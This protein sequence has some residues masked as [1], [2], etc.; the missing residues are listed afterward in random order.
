[1]AALRVPFNGQNVLDAQMATEATQLEGIV[2]I[3]YGERARANLT[4][5]V[6]TVSA[7][8]IQRVT[9]ASPDAAIQG[10]VTGV[11][12]TTE[13]GT[14]GAPVAMRI[15]GVGTV[16]NTQPLFV[17]D[18]VPV[19]KGASANQSPLATI[20]PNDIE[21]ISILKDASAASVYGMQAANGVVLITTRRGR[22]GAPTIRYDGYTGVQQMPRYYD[23]LSTEE[24]LA[25]QQ[26][27]IDANNAFFGRTP[28]DPA[29]LQLPPQL[30]Q[31][32]PE[33]AELLGRNTDW[34]RIGVNSN[35]P[36]TSH[37]VSISGASD[38]VNYYV[39]GGYFQQEAL[40]G[41]WDLSRYSFRANS[42][43]N[44]TD[45]LRLGETFTISNQVTDR[46]FSNYG[47]ATILANVISQPPVYLAYDPS[48]VG[49]TNPQGLAGNFGTLTGWSRSNM[50]SVDQLVDV[51]D[52]TTRVLGGIFAE[53]DVVRGLTLRTQNSVDYNIDNLYRWQP[54]FTGAVTGYERSEFAGDFRSEAYTFV[55]SNTATYT[56]SFG[57]HNFNVLGG[58]E[59]NLYRQNGVSF[60]ATGFI[61]TDYQLRRLV[62]LG[63]QPLAR[64]GSASEVNRLGY[65]GRLNYNY[66]DRYL[67]TASG[68]RDG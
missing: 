58:I 42:D 51:T 30:R 27:A 53:A 55:S 65:I 22:L 56:N 68:R 41:Q 59:T 35:A 14:P 16:G 5:S 13:S 24:W 63:D 7:Q 33:R 8:E 2:V 23:V 21:S 67:F 38:Q 29:F 44:V 6:G 4:E 9:V 61:S 17:I 12:V 64:R 19:G 62:A 57:N 43:F 36:I 11:Q 45:W 60:E 18:G 40:I 1:Y 46:G 48:L 15:R 54:A 10:R 32:A 39:S 20:N 28:S 66:G 31:G 47:D 3:G 25:L 37:N 52:R 26:E 34:T 50:N 49:P